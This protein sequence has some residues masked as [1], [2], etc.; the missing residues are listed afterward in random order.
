MA[1]VDAY[2][3]RDGKKVRIPEHWLGH[4]VLGR[5]FR[6]TP[7]PKTQAGT[8]PAV[9]PTLGGGADQKKEN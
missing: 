4:K 9:T 7:K 6:K 3:S 1:L 5:P 8:V 2:R